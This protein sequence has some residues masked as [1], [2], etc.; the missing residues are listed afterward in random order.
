MRSKTIKWLPILVT[1]MLKKVREKVVKE[2]IA[3]TNHLTTTASS[4]R[5]SSSLLR[6]RY[7]HR[8]KV[9]LSKS[10]NHRIS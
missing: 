3:V 9:I 1:K 7:E 10:L 8:I 2:E 5:T 4:M 6:S